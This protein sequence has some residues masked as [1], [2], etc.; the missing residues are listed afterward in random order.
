MTECP[1]LSTYEN[2]VE[3]FKECALYEWKD[4]GGVCPFKNLTEYKLRNIGDLEEFSSA[5][6]G[7]S[8][9]KETYLQGQDD[10]IKY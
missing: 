4:T 10:Y 2:V 8:Y 5:E 1:F 9:L 7:I 3:C 6:M